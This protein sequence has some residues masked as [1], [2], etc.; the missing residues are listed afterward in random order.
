MR[1]GLELQGL[2]KSFRGAPAPALDEVSLSLAPGSCTAV[3]GP[4]GSGKS[5]LL[6]TV[7]GLEIPDRGS[8]LL[9]GQDLAAVRPERRGM[10]MVFQRPLLFPHLNVRDNVAFPAT[11]RGVPR[12]R[13]RTDAESYLELVHMKGTGKRAVTDLSGGQQQRVAIARGLAARP[14]VLLLDEP[15]NALDPELRSA[16]HDLLAH[17]RKKLHPTILMVTHDHDEAAAVADRIA[18]LHAGRLLQHDPIDALYTRPA[19][20]QVSRLMGGTN[21]IPGTVKDGMHYSVLGA[22]ALPADQQ[23]PDGPA[24]LIIRQ[25]HLLL[26]PNHSSGSLAVVTGLRSRGPRRLITVT[27]AGVDLHAEVTPSHALSIGDSVRV[28]LPTAALAAVGADTAPDT[29]PLTS[30]DWKVLA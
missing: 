5:T 27:A 6:R 15:F 3:L 14:A 18:L 2:S 17:V 24:T 26:V 13:A 22:H 20:L 1:Q 28:Q 23:W 9:N 21:E 16:M 4:S 25:E 10:V 19:T 30:P 7:A 8:V 11:I 29:P 12:R